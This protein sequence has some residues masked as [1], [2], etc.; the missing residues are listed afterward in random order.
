MANC[1]FCCY[2]R[3]AF[4]LPKVSLKIFFI[5]FLLNLLLDREDLL[6]NLQ[7]DV[8]ARILVERYICCAYSDCQKLNTKIRKQ[9]LKELS[10]LTSFMQFFV[11]FL[12][13]FMVCYFSV[14]NNHLPHPQIWNKF[15]YPLCISSPAICD[16]C[17]TI[18]QFQTDNEM[19][20]NCWP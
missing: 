9:R 18:I 19:Q 15:N 12:G 1:K 10:V 14:E 17:I 2:F 16:K 6:F 8:F 20:F 11:F 3:V 4:D 7:L 13:I 5:T